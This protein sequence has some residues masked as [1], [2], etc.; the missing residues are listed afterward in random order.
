[1]IATRSFRSRPTLT[2]DAGRTCAVCHARLSI[3]N[4]SEYCSAHRPEPDWHYCGM[5]FSQCSVCG[6]VIQVKKDRKGLKCRRCHELRD[7]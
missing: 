6:E 1:M 7:S 4:E 3:Y 2:Y 5:D